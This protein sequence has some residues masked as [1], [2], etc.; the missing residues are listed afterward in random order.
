M[1]ASTASMCLRRES[2]SVHV[3]ISSHD[4]SRFNGLPSVDRYQVVAGGTFGCAGESV[5]FCYPRTVLFK[6]GGPEH[7]LTPVARYLLTFIRDV[8]DAG[9]RVGFLNGTR[10]FARG[11]D[12]LEVA[13][14]PIPFLDAAREQPSFQVERVAFGNPA[15][16]H[17][18]LFSHRAETG[19]RGLGVPF[20]PDKDLRLAAGIFAESYLRRRLVA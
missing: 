10:G 13:C 15:A 9:W 19:E 1:A 4:C 7:S 8:Y 18:R 2:L 11:Q 20:Q 5:S 12:D 16:Q 6:T 3:H 14:A 17:F